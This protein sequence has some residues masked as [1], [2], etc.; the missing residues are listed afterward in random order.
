[1]KHEPRK[2]NAEPLDNQKTGQGAPTDDL[3]GQPEESTSALFPQE[4]CV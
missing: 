4:S 3:S 2:I 1:M